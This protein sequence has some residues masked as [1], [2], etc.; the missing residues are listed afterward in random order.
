M[1]LFI[2][3]AC[4]RF[5]KTSELVGQLAPNL[6]SHDLTQLLQVSHQLYKSILPFFWRILNVQSGR[7]PNN[8]LDS[9]EG[10]QSFGKNS[11]LVHYLKTRAVFTTFYITSILVTQKESMADASNV[12][13]LEIPEWLP[14]TTT[15]QHQDHFSFKPLVSLHRL[16]CSM[17]WRDNEANQSKYKEEFNPEAHS[18][19]ICWM[20]MFTPALTYLTLED[21]SVPSPLF[22]RLLIRGISRLTSLRNLEIRSDVAEF[23]VLSMVTTLFDYLPPTL[24]SLGLAFKIDDDL[25]DDESFSLE[26]IP[27]GQGWEEG[28]LVKRVGPLANL[29]RLKLPVLSTGYR[30]AALCP[31]LQQCPKLRTFSIPTLS[32]LITGRAVGLT[33]H[34][35]CP[36]IRWVLIRDEQRY[37][38]A[39][40]LDL[41]ESIPHPQLEML[42]KDADYVEQQ[43]SR[44]DAILQNHLPTWRLVKFAGF[45]KVSSTTIQAILSGCPSLEELDL[46]PKV[47]G[48]AYVMLNDMVAEDW[49]CHKLRF[50]RVSVGL[51]IED[52]VSEDEG[53]VKRREE[54]FR[55]LA[56][57]IGS[58]HRLRALILAA[59]TI[60]IYGDA[61]LGE[62]GFSG[63][64]TLDDAASETFGHLLLLSGLR[65]LRDVRGNL[66]RRTLSRPNALGRGEVEFI[67]ENWP[68]M[69]KNQGCELVPRLL[70]EST[71]KMT[72]PLF[73]EWLDRQRPL[74]KLR[75]AA[76]YMRYVE[77]DVDD[78]SDDDS[79]MSYTA[80]I[81]VEMDDAGLHY[82]DSNDAG[83]SGAGSSDLS[84]TGSIE[85]LNDLVTSDDESSDA[86][87][88]DAGLNDLG[89]SDNGSSDAGLSDLELSE[90]ELSD[91]ESSD[92]DFSELGL[93]DAG[94]SDVGFSEQGLSDTG[95][96]DAAFSELGLSDA[97]SSDAGFSELGLSDIG[98]GFSD[99]G[100]S[101]AESSGSGSSCVRS[102]RSEP[103]E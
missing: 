59:V 29:I 90:L 64:L 27:G 66:I 40:V 85:G 99:L 98:S 76:D 102:P 67:A 72:F 83:S 91:A 100:L 58:L 30:A 53:V 32:S 5:F 28:P 8:L 84:D 33:I 36:E 57:Q 49:V 2:D 82:A 41:L 31:I 79:E 38:G 7:R 62:F 1:S 22:L 103:S 75:L 86:R 60:D 81:Y 94:S 69:K 95:S 87:S 45:C 9:Q 42:I 15:L 65:E 44:M 77:E 51:D 39:C 4:I 93:S 23:T 92:G 19:H 25:L 12:C 101:D 46:R 47:P 61:V 96:S 11:H 74:I 34:E 71:A 48:D 88:I 3:T 50:L 18:I 56:R 54:H 21:L 6:R 97:G 26:G 52:Q 13:T 14:R 68:L 80:S 10:L 37:E 73:L 16:H 20:I 55:D 35:H 70:R 17:Q 43:P 89:L 63:A 24:F 78:E